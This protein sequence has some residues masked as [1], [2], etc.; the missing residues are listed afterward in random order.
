MFAFPESQA[1]TCPHSTLTSS[2]SPYAPEAGYNRPTAQ[3]RATAAGLKKGQEVDETAFPAP[4]VLPNDDLAYDPKWPTQSLRSWVREKERNEVT[5]DRKTI[6]IAAPP[7]IAPEVCK[8]VAISSAPLFPGRSSKHPGITVPSPQAQE[9]V[10][11]LAAF[12][13]GLPVKL[14]SPKDTPLRFTAWDDSNS[15]PSKKRTTSTNPTSIALATS[16]E[17]IRIRARPCPDGAF[18]S[19]LNLNDILDV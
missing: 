9:V 13:H 17:A 15:K 19:Q 1:P 11:Y 12:F 5:P 3:Q 2:S 8:S 18:P 14:L 6:Y 7:D 16:I 4:L 10:D